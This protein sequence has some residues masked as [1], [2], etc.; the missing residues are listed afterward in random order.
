MR[1]HLS[2]RQ[3]EHGRRVGSS[4]RRVPAVTQ[5][6]QVWSGVPTAATRAARSKTRWMPSWTPGRQ[7]TFDDDAK[8]VPSLTRPRRSN[9]RRPAGEERATGTRVPPPDRTR[10]SRRPVICCEARV[11]E[12]TKTGAAGMGG[13]RTSKR[14]WWRRRECS[15]HRRRCHLVREKRRR[16]R[17]GGESGWEGKG[18]ERVGRILSG[19]VPMLASSRWC[20]TACCFTSPVSSGRG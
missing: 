11:H 1:C 15:V 9:A 10:S 2:L 14:L 3:T 4:V 18:G 16:W 5:R 19:A 12:P 8:R 6:R 7:S 13:S 17:R 20:P